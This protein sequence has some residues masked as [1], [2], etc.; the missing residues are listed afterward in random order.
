VTTSSISLS[1]AAPLEDGGSEVTGYS[2]YYQKSVDSASADLLLIQ[3]DS[4]EMTVEDLEVNTE[5]FF[6]VAATNIFGESV[7]SPAVNQMTDEAPP[8]P[9]PPTGLSAR[10]ADDE[11]EQFYVLYTPSVNEGPYPVT[12]YNVYLSKWNTEEGAYAEEQQLQ[13]SPNSQNEL[14]ITP[15]QS[16]ST[17]R[18]EITA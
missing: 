4:T 5:Y 16:G 14:L 10:Q 12:I 9:G 13:L 8:I 18:V 3:T 7:S 11:P 17:Y 1:W 2:V 6:A 15:V